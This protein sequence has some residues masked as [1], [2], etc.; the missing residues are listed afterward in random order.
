MG[1]SEKRHQMMLARREHLDIA[2]E[3]HLVVIGVEDG[4]Q[5][6]GRR[7][8]QPREL[9]GQRTSDPARG[10]LD[11]VP[12]RVLANSE[13]DLV[14]RSLHPPEVDLVVQFRGPC[15]PSSPGPW[16]L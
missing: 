3:H 2:H 1:M 8:P 12:R 7:L 10:V 16:P 4:R 9:L 6:I 15:D 11:T 14:Y 5:D 13:Q